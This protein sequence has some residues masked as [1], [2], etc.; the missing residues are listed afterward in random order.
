MASYI[1]PRAA[2]LLSSGKVSLASGN[3]PTYT[4]SQ[5][6]IP[7]GSG[8][9]SL[10]IQNEFEQKT[11]MGYQEVVKAILEDEENDL[12][13]VS[14]S[15]VAPYGGAPI[16]PFSPTSELVPASLVSQIPALKTGATLPK[17]SALEDDNEESITSR[18]KEIGEDLFSWLTGKQ[19]LT[20]QS[21]SNL[22]SNVV[23]TVTDVATLPATVLAST[24]TTTSSAL[25]TSLSNLGSGLGTGLGSVAE[26]TT[27]GLGEG[28]Q[29]LI[30]PGLLVLGGIY[31]L[32]K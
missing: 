32:K 22:F 17:V 29:K 4:S 30:L 12:T 19:T 5:I 3:T 15:N 25:G 7:S 1:S 28:L 8:S 10:R 6:L 14:M 11:S 16:N 2:A 18:I 9:G 27:S 13:S 20:G 26:N 31:L 21:T 23:G 24:L